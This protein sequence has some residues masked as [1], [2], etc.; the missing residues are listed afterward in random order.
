MIN[1]L[2]QQLQEMKTENDVAKQLKTQMLP[3][4]KLQ[5]PSLEKNKL[6]AI[7]TI[8]DPRCKKVDF[9]DLV[10][11]SHAVNKIRE[12]LQ[13]QCPLAYTPKSSSFE[14]I[15]TGKI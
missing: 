2:A 14:E 1:G 12:K 7:A 9:K 13:E 3:E 10:A 4:I 11:C 5:F 6:Y 15:V 8:L